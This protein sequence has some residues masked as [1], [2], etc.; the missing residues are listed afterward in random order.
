MT[1]DCLPHQVV[2]EFE[3]LPKVVRDEVGK[4]SL[5]V[6]TGELPVVSLV[7][8]A[9]LVIRA[10][11]EKVLVSL[12]T[13][14]LCK[15]LCA[16]PPEAAS[17]WRWPERWSAVLSE[18][19]KMG[20]AFSKGLHKASV[21]TGKSAINLRA[22]I[23]GHRQ[24]S[25]RAVGLLVPE[26]T[27]LDLRDNMISPDEIADLGRQ[28]AQTKGVLTKL[29]LGGNHTLHASSMV[30]FCHACLREG[31]SSL[32]DLDVSRLSCGDATD[33][34]IGHL[35]NVITLGGGLRNLVLA[36]SGIA[37]PAAATFITQ[38]GRPTPTVRRRLRLITPGCA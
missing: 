28:L 5:L 38:L 30:A 7:S 9:P 20:K 35:A 14:V 18:G 24:T 29:M 12:V 15:G 1:T 36:G 23:G 26:I 10:K 27:S 13:R 25:L 3:R 4:V 16:L 8:S 11:N 2:K 21:A 34:E 19:A 17:P 33:E 22:L 37:D 6:K 32:A 31:T